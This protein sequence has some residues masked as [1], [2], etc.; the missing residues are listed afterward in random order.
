MLGFARSSVYVDL[1]PRT[2][3]ELGRKTL[4]GYVVFG[5]RARTAETLLAGDSLKIKHDSGKRSP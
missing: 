5:G 2:P 4:R 3:S 1:T